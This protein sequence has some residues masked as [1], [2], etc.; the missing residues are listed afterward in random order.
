MR[1]LRLRAGEVVEVPVFDSKKNWRVK[2]NVLRRERVK[3]PWGGIA[4]LLIEPEIKSASFFRSRGKVRL[5]VSEDRRH[6]P[7]RLEVRSVI[8]PFAAHLIE[9]RGLPSG[10]LAGPPLK[11][12][13]EVRP[14]AKTR[15]KIVF[16][17][18]HA[19]KSFQ[20]K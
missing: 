18:K 7:F 13:G 9:T 14:G 5:W 6:V 3:S 20:C 8:G 17:P 4:T 16:P 2:V 19:R 1:S 15:K 10:P 12:P 11:M